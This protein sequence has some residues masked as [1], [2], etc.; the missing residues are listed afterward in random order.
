[1]AKLVLKSSDCVVVAVVSPQQ[2]FRDQARAMIEGAGY[3]FLEV[4]VNS[5][6]AICIER[7]VKG[8]YKQALLGK[9]PLFT[10][11]SDPYE[12]PPSADVTCFTDK[13]TIRESVGKIVTKLG[14]S[15]PATPHALFIG[16]WAPF[17]KGHWAIMEAVRKEKPDRPLLIFVRNTPNEYWPAAIRKKMVENS[18]KTMHIDATVVI[19]PDID[20]V[21]WGRDVGYAPRFIDVDAH[22]HAVSGTEIRRKMALHEPDWK[23]FLCPGVAEVIERYHPPLLEEQ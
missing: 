9:I 20:S 10:G 7:D 15:H 12:P 6:L 21:N 3:R 1:M 23:A 14:V 5:P 11:V 2:T 4:Y 22:V 17:H 16:R 18:M 13:E 8:L 19:I